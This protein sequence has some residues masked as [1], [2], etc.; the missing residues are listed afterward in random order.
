MRIGIDARFLGATNSNLAKY[1]ENLLLAL[2]RRDAANQYVVFVH[3]NL[4]RK[5]KLGANFRLVPMR[6]RPMGLGAIVRLSAAVRREQLD[7]V[8]AHFPLMPLFHGRPTFITVHDLLPFARDHGD[9]GTRFR[10]WRWLWTYLLYPMSVQR[11]KWIVCVSAATRRSLRDLFPDSFQKSVVVHSGVNESF[12]A[13]LEAATRELI[14]AHLE[15][16]ERYLLY[17]GSARADKNLAGLMR[18]FAELR[19]RD[20]AQEDLHLVLEIAGEEPSGHLIERLIVTHRLESRVRVI[21]NAGEEERRVLFED[22]RALVLLSR[23]EGFGFPVLEAQ[24]C[25]LPVMVADSGALPEVAGEGALLVDP[26]NLEE[27]VTL[28]ERLLTDETLR[29]YLI[30]KGRANAKR[31]DWNRAADWLVQMFELLT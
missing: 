30:E 15:L 20:A 3:G 16:P 24:L 6:G 27:T 11:C 23:N 28:L 21:R 13:P 22:A 4:K 1:S 7:V 12:R 29:A 5:L 8:H 26:D 2:A 19:R 17:S 25:G 10:P 18:A 9:F 14:R 31:F